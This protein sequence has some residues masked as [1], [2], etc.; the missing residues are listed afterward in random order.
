M[1]ELDLFTFWFNEKQKDYVIIRK[2]DLSSLNNGTVPI[3]FVRADYHLVRDKVIAEKV[4][5]EKGIYALNNELGLEEGMEM[6][7]C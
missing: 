7:Q 6:T 5:E 1:N 4:I 3:T 2:K